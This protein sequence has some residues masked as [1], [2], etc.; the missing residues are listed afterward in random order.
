MSIPRPIVTPRSAIVGRLLKKFDRSIS[1]TAI[2]VNVR[3]RK[4]WRISWD[5]PTSS[6]IV[7]AATIVNC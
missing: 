5:S 3:R 2:V 7:P 6:G 1:H 4:S